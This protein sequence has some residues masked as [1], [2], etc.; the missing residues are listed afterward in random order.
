MS[1]TELMTVAPSLAA[2]PPPA[3]EN[4]EAASLSPPQH[5]TEGGNPAEDT[6]AG[7]ALAPIDGGTAAWRLL[8]AAFVFETLL[9]GETDWSSMVFMVLAADRANPRVPAFLWGLP[10]L[11]LTDARVCG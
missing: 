1:S 8:C 7:Q 4:I 10:R 9:W 3:V 2:A 6:Q 11:L 5:D